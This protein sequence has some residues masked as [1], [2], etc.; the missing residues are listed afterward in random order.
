[1]NYFAFLPALVSD[2][3][4]F[5]DA[6]GFFVMPKGPDGQQFAALGGQGM[7]INS[8]ID[9]AHKQAAY[10]F[11]KWFSQEDIQDKWAEYGGYTCNINVLNSDKFLKATPYNAAF[12]QT[13]T[14]VKDFWNIPEFGQ[15]LAPTQ[16][17]LSGYVVSGQGEAKAVL[18]QLAEDQDKILVDA[19][20]IQ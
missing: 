17:A 13:M 1:M 16:T 20:V 5:K 12:A 19:G 8:Y 18:D 2:T 15:L 10:D 11:L 6:T 3:N 7:S 9:D 4:K 14:F